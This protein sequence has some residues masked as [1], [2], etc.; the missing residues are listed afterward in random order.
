MVS[1]NIKQNIVRVANNSELAL[2]VTLSG[3]DG[4]VLLKIW[5]ST[6]Q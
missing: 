1:K 3:K 5:S 4:F 6:F 2:V